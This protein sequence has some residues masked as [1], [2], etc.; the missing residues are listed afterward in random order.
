MRV[1]V[2]LSP[3]VCVCVCQSPDVCVC[4]CVCVCVSP[5]VCCLIERQVGHHRGLSRG[6]G[7]QRKFESCRT[8][9]SHRGKIK[10]NY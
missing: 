9:S 6:A 7:N 8:A 1:C 10:Y 5:D 3:D 2:C 4:V